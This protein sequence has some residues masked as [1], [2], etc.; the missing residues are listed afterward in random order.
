MLKGI[1]YPIL[2]GALIGSVGCLAVLLLLA[3]VAA[4]MDIP[5]VAVV[6]LATI[7][8]AVGAFLGGLTSAKIA[9]RNGWLVGV[10]TAGILFVMSM[11]AG[12]GLFSQMNMGF[13]GIKL[14]VMIACG[15]TGGIL[16]VNSGKKRKR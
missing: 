8:A 15:M 12:G 4:G 7:G 6:P 11:L 3:I 13:V 2:L 16:A 9:G 10:I 1:L 5:P 14:L